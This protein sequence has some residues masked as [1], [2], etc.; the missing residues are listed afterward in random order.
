[1]EAETLKAL[2]VSVGTGVEV[3]RMAI[4]NLASAIVF[5]INSQNPDK[6]FLIVSEESEKTTL[7][8][9]LSRTTARN[10]ETIVV[11]DP[12]NI[13]QIY[14]D[15]QPK[16]KQIREEYDQVAVDYTSGTKAM[17]G[18]LTILGCI[19]EAN[20]LNYVA[21]K[22][23]NGIVQKG[24]EKIYTV[25]PIFAS[26]EQ[27]IRTA[28]EFFNK[29]QFG[30]AI[31]LLNQMEKITTDTKILSRTRPLKKLAQ[32]YEQWDSFQHVKAFQTLRKID[33][34]QLDNNKRF[35]GQ[36]THRQ[37]ETHEQK[38]D[39]KRG[40]EPEPYYI[41]DLLNNARR[42]GKE[43]AKYDDAV[44]R[45]YRTIE[46]VAQYQLRTKHNI[47]TSAVH[48][49]QLNE[50]LAKKW[51]VNNNSSKIQIGL[52]RA[53]EL[54]AAKNDPIGAR[55]HDD[56]KLKNLLSKRNTSILAHGLE[57]VTV[58]TYAELYKKTFEYARSAIKNLERLVA[59][60]QFIKWKE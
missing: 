40:R 37:N 53:Y 10:C 18:A 44:A 13:E 50:E 55:F 46:L 35:L 58:K 49:E 45:L 31:V 39:E 17:T 48:V 23:K 11:R 60:A 51:D 30:A 34:K 8:R 24:T 3:G 25:Q 29:N 6:V 57:P 12:D 15:L 33:S 26:A 56:N 59:D 54:L 32:A 4:E 2:L 1:M 41:A 38:M 43:E 42:R 5:S 52:E 16:L 21:G 20:T 9:I 22:R 7:P 28:I 19:Y 36:L 27:K 47:Q 14:Q